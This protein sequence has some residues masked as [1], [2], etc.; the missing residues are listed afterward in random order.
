MEEAPEAIDVLASRRMRVL[1]PEKPW[2]DYVNSSAA[3]TNINATTLSTREQKELEEFK[4]EQ[5]NIQLHMADEALNQWKEWCSSHPNP[6]NTSMSLKKLIDF[7]VSKVIPQENAILRQLTQDSRIPISGVESLLL[8][9]LRHM[10]QG[11]ESAK[12]RRASLSTHQRSPL[13]VS[14][15]KGP[16][17]SPVLPSCKP[18]D[19]PGFQRSSRSGY[20]T[21][22]DQAAPK[23]DSEKEEE[24]EEEVSP[25]TSVWP[26]R[27]RTTSPSAVLDDVSCLENSLEIV[28]TLSAEV[29]TICK[30]AHM[31]NI[32][33]S[34]SNPY[35]LT[36]SFFARLRKDQVK[37]E[38]LGLNGTLYNSL[39]VEV[40][41][42]HVQLVQTLSVQMSNRVMSLV[43]ASLAKEHAVSTVSTVPSSLVPYSPL[44]T[45]LSAGMSS[46]VTSKKASSGKAFKTADQ[47][48]A[49]SDAYARAD[50]DQGTKVKDQICADNQSVD[51]QAAEC[52]T[53]ISDRSKVDSHDKNRVSKAETGEGSVWLAWQRWKVGEDGSLPLEELVKRKDS[54]KMVLELRNYCTIAEYISG[55]IERLCAGGMKLEIAIQSL[56]A[57]RH[58]SLAT[59]AM[60]IC[61]E[62]DR[63]CTNEELIFGETRSRHQEHSSLI[64][65]LTGVVSSRSAPGPTAEKPLDHLALHRNSEVIST[66]APSRAPLA[67]VEKPVPKLPFASHVAQT[68]STFSLKTIGLYSDDA[69]Q[70]AGID[71]AA[72]RVVVA[73]TAPPLEATSFVTPGLSHVLTGTSLS[74]ESSAGS[75]R[76][77]FKALAAMNT[78]ASTLRPAFTQWQ[79]STQL[80]RDKPRGESRQNMPGSPPFYSLSSTIHNIQP[81]PRNLPVAGQVLTS[82]PVTLQLLSTLNNHQP[83]PQSSRLRLS[84]APSFRS[85]SF[86]SQG[87]FSHPPSASAAPSLSSRLSFPPIQANIQ[88]Y[89][90]APSYPGQVPVI[91]LSQPHMPILP[92]RQVSSLPMSQ[93][94]TP[95]VQYAPRFEQTQSDLS[96]P[97]STRIT[98]ARLA[99]SAP[100]P[101][102]L[103]DDQ[104]VMARL[105]IPGSLDASSTSNAIRTTFNHFSQ[106][107]SKTLPVSHAPA[108]HSKRHATELVND[109]PN[110]VSTSSTATA[111]TLGAHIASSI[112]APTPS[113]ATKQQATTPATLISTATT[114]T[115]ATT[116]A[117]TPKVTI[118]PITAPQQALTVLA[119]QTPTTGILP[120][121]P[122]I[123]TATQVHGTAV[124][125]VPWTPGTTPTSSATLVF[126]PI[127]L[128]QPMSASS[129]TSATVGR[130]QVHLF[131]FNFEL[132]TVFDIWDLWTVGIQGGPSV[133]DLIE[134]HKL[135]WLHPADRETYQDYRSV[136]LIVERSVR[137]LKLDVR[138]GLAQLE[139][140]RVEVKMSVRQFAK[141]LAEV[142]MG[143]ATPARPSSILGSLPPSSSLLLS[144]ALPTGPAPQTIQA[145]V[146]VID[147]MMLPQPSSITATLHP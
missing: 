9:L 31:P 38:R 111:A 118:P 76:S 18:H 73:P 33:V 95:L 127:A 125:Q 121:A 79:T 85:T 69:Q 52:T 43:P 1:I 22:V 16:H 51:M 109:V 147:A 84:R 98:L 60:A 3:F 39:L 126:K 89:Y 32:D 65:G 137:L 130:E 96:A 106:C 64:E 8:P 140:V 54:D 58:L 4:D 115:T 11:E 142:D 57:R 124:P 71:S 83:T 29:E 139:H 20:V 30:S 34:E 101:F 122:V 59:L 47:D 24:E 17:P 67:T 113:F 49:Q 116:A 136:L 107:A 117:M 100:T 21:T 77:A 40:L 41:E 144:M 146:K 68:R 97:T 26:I 66:L 63:R 93:G 75:L 46:L 129:T 53:A 123:V 5:R 62:R 61:Q 108:P 80:L 105:D 23:G 37:A 48:V 134:K 91:P 28:S 74:A 55:E 35:L 104:G 72:S 42:G 13:M 78:T 112:I 70:T 10:H 7:I 99:P 44:K 45:P 82:T 86:G 102:N 110:I 103:A 12:A 6:C 25:W 56:E 88:N 143:K 131:R 132:Q 2:H 128:N 120:L 90:G 135:A 87:S 27:D 15:R 36:E 133:A 81:I 92:Q 14:I 141:I 114:A 145:F 50:Q 19:P 119:S 138:V 94:P